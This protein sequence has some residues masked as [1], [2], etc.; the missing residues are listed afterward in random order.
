MYII[1]RVREKTTTGQLRKTSG[2]K[3]EHIFRKGTVKQYVSDMQW[4][5]VLQC[6]LKKT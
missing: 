4:E 2:I 3:D 6:E 1:F 5:V